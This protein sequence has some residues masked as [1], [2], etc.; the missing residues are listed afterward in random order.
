MGYCL[1]CQTWCVQLPLWGWLCFTMF[2]PFTTCTQ[3][4][5][6][7]TWCG[8]TQWLCLAHR[9]HAKPVSRYLLFG[10]GTNNTT[11]HM[12]H[13]LLACPMEQLIPVVLHGDEGRGKRR[14][15]TTVFS[16]ESPIGIKGHSSVCTACAPT[17]SWSPQCAQGH[18]FK[19]LLRSNMKSP[20]MLTAL[21]NVFAARHLMEN[22]QD[23]Y[24]WAD[25]IS[26]GTVWD[27][28]STMALLSMEI[29]IGWWL[30]GRKATWSGWVR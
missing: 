21:A 11:P 28:C 7:S 20:L 18:P 15:N 4:S 13:S 30:W 10:R 29:T 17:G 22:L 5:W 19:S 3:R 8:A 6:L 25:H 1:A 9:M 23:A 24:A 27:S 14:S 26:V 12:L 2:Y 16:W